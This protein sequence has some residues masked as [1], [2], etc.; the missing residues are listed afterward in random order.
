MFW[1]FSPFKIRSILEYMFDPTWLG[2]WLQKPLKKTNNL[3]SKRHQQIDQFLDR[4]F[5]DL[6]SVFGGNLEPCR[7]PF[8]VQDGPRGLQDDLKTPPRRSRDVSKMISRPKQG[9]PIGPSRGAPSFQV[10]LASFLDHFGS[11][12]DP[13]IMNLLDV[14]PT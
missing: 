14:R 2:F 12:F 8:S 3:D 5:I 1:L 6:G 9:Y 13:Q 11:Q 4:F 10:V 7:L